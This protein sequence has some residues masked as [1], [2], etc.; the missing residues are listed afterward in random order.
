MA[1]TDLKQ[2]E[3][4]RLCGGSWFRDCQPVVAEKAWL[5]EQL[6]LLPGEKSGGQ[7]LSH[8]QGSAGGLQ[9]GRAT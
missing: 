4:G 9:V 7:C 6:W 3:G 5:R 2:L 1:V 8:L